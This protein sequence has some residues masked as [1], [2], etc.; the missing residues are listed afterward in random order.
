VV[1]ALLRRWC[2]QTDNGTA[3][4]GPA[5]KQR[6]GRWTV[7]RR[8]D[9]GSIGL[10]VGQSAGS[11]I[12]QFDGSVQH[13]REPAMRATG[14]DVA[15]QCACMR[16]NLSTTSALDIHL[17]S[18]RRKQHPR[19]SGTRNAT[20][21]FGRRNRAHFALIAAPAMQPDT[22]CLVT[23]ALPATS[24]HSI[25]M[26]SSV[27]RSNF[28]RSCR[29]HSPRGD[30][31]FSGGMHGTQTARSPSAGESRPPSQARLSAG[32]WDRR[33]RANV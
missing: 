16:S 11:S 32:A 24:R 27:T 10:S 17:N 1:S 31:G 26:S 33:A 30:S 22:C 9:R 23:P 29:C 28:S 2:R 19:C 6:K 13:T 18:L 8:S 20:P 5:L 25:L 7:I 15:W 3:H 4:S 14:N 21:H 12:D